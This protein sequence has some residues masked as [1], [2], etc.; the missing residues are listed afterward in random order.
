MMNQQPRVE[1]NLVPYKWPQ[2][3][4]ICKK[5]IEIRT[6][7]KNFAAAKKKEDKIEQSGLQVW[8]MIYG[9]KIREEH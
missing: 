7:Y 6:K 4:A 3:E 8:P 1:F 5:Q 2:Y 9:N